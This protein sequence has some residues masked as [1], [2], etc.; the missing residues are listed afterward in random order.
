M[1][2]DPAPKKYLKQGLS[3]LHSRV[4]ALFDGVKDDHHHCAMDNL[5]NSAAFCKAAYNHPRKVLVHG[6]TRK[7]MRSIPEYVKQEEEKCRK[8]Q[9]TVRETVKA[10]VLK[11]DPKCPNLIAT[12]IYDSK[13][14]HYLSMCT[15]KWSEVKKNVYNRETGEMDSMKFLWVNQIHKYSSEMGHVDMADQL[16]G[17]YRM[18]H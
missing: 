5:Y 16:R 1:R 13:P 3:P 7:E 8:K 12:S 10:A 17:A 15:E 6:V 18:D 4:M 2:N 14:V 9:L 11:G